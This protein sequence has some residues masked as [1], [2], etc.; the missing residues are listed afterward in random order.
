MKGILHLFYCV[1]ITVLFVLER[2]EV[3]ASEEVK[4]LLEKITGKIILT[5][6]V[7]ILYYL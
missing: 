3:V 1:C 5:I 7:L 4:L 6:I 2:E